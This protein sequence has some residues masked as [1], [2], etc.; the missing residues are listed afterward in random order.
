M[1]SEGKGSSRRLDKPNRGDARRAFSASAHRPALRTR[2]A[3]R[4]PTLAGALKPMAPIDPGQ[5]ARAIAEI[6]KA[7]AALRH[8]EPSLEFWRPGSAARGEKRNYLSVWF[9]IGGIWISD[10]LVLSATVG[11]IMYI[12]G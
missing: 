11:A 3:G 2:E 7:S 6:E 9:L 4:A 5:L 12:F 10:I 1:V 8:S